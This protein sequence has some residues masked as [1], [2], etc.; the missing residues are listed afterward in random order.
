MENEYSPQQRL[1]EVNKAIRAVLLGGQSYK[2]GSQTSPF[3]GP[4]GMT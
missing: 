2:I 3:S 4:C 1:H